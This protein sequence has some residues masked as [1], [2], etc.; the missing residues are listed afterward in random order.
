[1]G[2][3]TAFEDVM[4]FAAEK[5]ARAA[6]RG[7]LWAS[8]TVIYEVAARYSQALGHRPAVR[9]PLASPGVYRT[10]AAGGSSFDPRRSGRGSALLPSMKPV[11]RLK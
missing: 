3:N 11:N 1:M 4:S 7:V 5:M 6:H 2:C 8:R 9:T 10:T